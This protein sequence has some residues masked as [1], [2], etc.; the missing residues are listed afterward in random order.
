VSRPVWVLRGARA[1]SHPLFLR[2]PVS[3]RVQV[4]PLLD[5]GLFLFNLHGMLLRVGI[6]A[7]PSDL[8]RNLGAGF[9]ASDFEAITRDL[10]G[11]VE[12]R[13]RSADRGELG[14]RQAH[15]LGPWFTLAPDDSPLLLRDTGVN[16]IFALRLQLP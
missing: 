6:L 9:A 7:N 16:E 4:I 8:P 11:D 1:P 3:V 14:V 12:I 2:L 5:G 13:T 10:L 15:T